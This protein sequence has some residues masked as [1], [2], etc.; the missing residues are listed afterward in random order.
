MS[1]NSSDPPE[2]DAAVLAAEVKALRALLEEVQSGLGPGVQSALRERSTALQHLGGELDA[3][4]DEAE[5]LRLA[6]EAAEARAAEL[7][8]EAARWRTAARKGL[9][10]I[11]VKAKAAAERFEAQTTELNADLSAMRAELEASRSETSAVEAQRR[12]AA[13]ARDK[14]VA[15]AASMTRSWSWRLTAPLRRTAE[16]VHRLLKRGARLRRGKGG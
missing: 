3:H 1:K 8:R 4:R 14:A 13:S 10:E 15:L 9:Q 12:A 11:S 5:R 6:L 16:A 7:E 2:Q